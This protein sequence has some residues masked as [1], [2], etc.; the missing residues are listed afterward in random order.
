MGLA[1]SLNES[2]FEVIPTSLI[3]YVDCQDKRKIIA[4]VATVIK[5]E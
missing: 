4:F 1:L 3:P 5:V 2:L